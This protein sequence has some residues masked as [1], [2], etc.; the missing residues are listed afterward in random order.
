MKICCHTMRV[1]EVKCDDW[2][3]GC[4]IRSR[5]DA[6]AN[7]SCHSL[8]LILTLR[9]NHIFQIPECSHAAI[10]NDDLL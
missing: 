7:R 10:Y 9:V 2:P 3:V 1:G 4:L 8:T 5:L 6:E